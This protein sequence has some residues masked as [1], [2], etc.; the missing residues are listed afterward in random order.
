M[1]VIRH[2]CSPGSHLGTTTTPVPH[3]S[4]D[5]G[6]SAFWELDNKRKWK[7]GQRKDWRAEYR[8]ESVGEQNGGERMEGSRIQKSRVGGSRGLA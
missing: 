8:R 7:R 6:S 2:G 3:I 1:Q 5:A 4:Q